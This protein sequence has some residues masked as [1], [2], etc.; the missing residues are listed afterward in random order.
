MEQRYLLIK[1]H[2]QISILSS[3][4]IRYHSRKYLI[5]RFLH[6]ALQSRAGAS[7]IILVT[8]VVRLII[9]NDGDS[10]DRFQ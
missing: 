6:A 3:A 5:N 9:D 8:R 7:P 2:K 1:R 10:S 4:S